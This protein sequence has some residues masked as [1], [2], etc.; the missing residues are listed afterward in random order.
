MA[1]AVRQFKQI[2]SLTALQASPLTGAFDQP[3]LSG[4]VLVACGITLNDTLYAP[5]TATATTDS[6]PNTW[7]APVNVSVANGPAAWFTYAMNVAAGSPTISTAMSASNLRVGAGV[8]E[9]TGAPTT[10][11]LILLTAPST[12]HAFGTS[13]AL[14][15]TVS[16]NTTEALAQ[17]DNLIIVVGGGPVGDPSNTGGYT[18]HLSIANGGTK[19]GAQIMSKVVAATTA[20]TGTLTHESVANPRVVLM[21]GFAEAAVAAVKVTLPFKSSEIEAADGPVSVEVWRNAHPRDEKASYYADSITPGTG[22]VDL[23]GIP[24]T[25][26]AADAI[27]GIVY[28]GTDTSGYVTGSVTA[29]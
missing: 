23:P 16:T 20:L 3:V 29:V 17:A 8:F 27:V 19:I 25:W 4:S 15:T 13:T 18:E 28:N 9:I 11:A 7:Q 24:Q 1:I 12:Y 2:D 26:T 22:V 10:G 21:F 14:G 5:A 6:Q